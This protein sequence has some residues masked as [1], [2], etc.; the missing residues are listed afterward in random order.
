MSIDKSDMR[1]L[2]TL[3]RDLLDQWYEAEKALVETGIMFRGLSFRQLKY[4]KGKYARQINAI[5]KRL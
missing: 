2:A 4:E 1:N 3:A 5:I